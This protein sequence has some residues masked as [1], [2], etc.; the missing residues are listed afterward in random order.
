[1][2]SAGA[3]LATLSSGW[4]GRVHRHGFAVVLAAAGWGVAIVGAGLAHT[5]W[6]AVTCLVLAGGSDMVSG[7]FRMTIWKQQVGECRYR[8]RRGPHGTQFVP[9]RPIKV[10]LVS[11]V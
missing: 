9:V 6:L 8:A 5:L 4:T 7:L 2:P 10:H 1:V 3:L 11:V